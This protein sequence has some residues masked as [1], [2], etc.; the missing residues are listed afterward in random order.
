M[1][2]L[3]AL[4]DATQDA[5]IKLVEQNLRNASQ[6]DDE[7]LQKVGQTIRKLRLRA[8]SREQQ[9]HMEHLQRL[10]ETEMHRRGYDY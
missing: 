7:A 1:G 8:K 5:T 4:Y 2:F 3:S 6:L 10:W 9:R